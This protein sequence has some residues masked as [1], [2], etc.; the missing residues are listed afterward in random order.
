MVQ[1]MN[2]LIWVDMEMTGLNPDTDCI[3]EVALVVTDSQL[4][5]VAEGPVLVVS[6]PDAILDA[7]DKWNTSTHTKSGL[8]DKVKTSKLSEALLAIS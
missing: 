2:N 5:V 4:N 3:I 1:D 6:Q 7:M 8:I